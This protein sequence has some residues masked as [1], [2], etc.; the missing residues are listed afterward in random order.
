MSAPTPRH[1]FGGLDGLVDRTTDWGLSWT[2]VPVV[3]TA[4]IN[5][6]SAPTATNYVAAPRAG[7]PMATTTGGASWIELDAGAHTDALRDIDAIDSDMLIGSISDGRILVPPM[8]VT[9]RRTAPPASRRTTYAEWRS[10]T[11]TASSRSATAAG[12]RRPTMAGPTGRSVR[13]GPC[14]TC[15]T[16]TCRARASPLPLEPEGRS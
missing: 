5:A 11:R 10:S 9:R 6:I 4:E 1:W 2:R 14:R 16:S 15:G 13:R 8:A 7:S 3:S 12:S